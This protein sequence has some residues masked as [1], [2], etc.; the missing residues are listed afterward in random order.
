MLEA[1]GRSIAIQASPREKGAEIT[2]SYPKEI[3]KAKKGWG[4]G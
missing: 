2:K 3:T 1:K 4:H